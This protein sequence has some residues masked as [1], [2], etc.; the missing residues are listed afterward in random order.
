MAATKRNA[1]VT[2]ATRTSL[3]DEELVR[4]NVNFYWQACFLQTMLKQ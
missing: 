1:G 2:L 3:N 4:Y